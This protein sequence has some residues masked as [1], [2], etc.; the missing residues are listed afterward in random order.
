[1]LIFQLLFGLSVSCFS[2]Y[3]SSYVIVGP[4]FRKLFWISAFFF[5]NNQK[6]VKASII[7]RVRYRQQKA[8]KA[9]LDAWTVDGIN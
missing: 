1:M 6:V 4:K 7:I 5:S 9:I 2:S 8:E 3:F